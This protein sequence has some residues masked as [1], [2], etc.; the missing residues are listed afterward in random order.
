MSTGANITQLTVTTFANIFSSNTVTANIY[1][2][3][4]GSSNIQN[5][6]VSTGANITQLTVTTLANISNANISTANIYSANVVVANVQYLNISYYANLANLSVSQFANINTAN[7]VTVFHSNLNVSSNANIF[8]MNVFT[9]NVQSTLNAMYATMT[10]NYY[11]NASGVW[12]LNISNVNS[13]T[14]PFS[15]TLGLGA[16]GISINGI[17]GAAGQYITA[18]GTGSGLQWGGPTATIIWAQVPGFVSPPIYYSTANVGMGGPYSTMSWGV[19]SSTVNQYP[20]TPLDVYGGL[21]SFSNLMDATYTGTIRIQNQTPTFG[22]NGGLEFKTG[23]SSSGSGHRILTTTDSTGLSPLIFQFRSSTKTWSNAMAINCDAGN[24]SGYV[25]IGTMNPQYQLHVYQPSVSATLGGILV[26]VSQASQQSTYSLQNSASGTCVFYLNGSSPSDGPANSATLRN[27]AGDLRLAGASTQPYIYLQTATNSVGFG[28]Q[29]MVASSNVSFWCPNVSSSG[30][31]Y[32]VSADSKL[33]VSLYAGD[34]GQ[35]QFVITGVTNT[36]KRLA[37]MYDTSNNISLIQSMT[38][39]TGTNPLILN[40]AGGNVGVGLTNPIRQFSMY[41]EFALVSPYAQSY[42]NVCDANG[43]NGGNYTLYLRGL[44]SSGGAGVNMAGCYIYA[45]NTYLAG[46]VGVGIVNPLYTLQVGTNAGIIGSTTLH[47]ANSYLDSAGQ[48]GARITALDNGV[49]GHNVQIQTR[50]SA[51][52]GFTNSV[53]V[54]SAG[55]VGINNT[56]P[57]APLHVNTTGT[58]GII[59]SGSIWGHRIVYGNYGVS[60]YQDGGSFYYLIT[61]SGDQYG[62]YNSLRPFSF[63]L[64]SGYV[65]MN[66]GVAIYSGLTANGGS[67]LNGSATVN[68]GLTVNG[69]STLNGSATVNSGLTV[70]GGATVNGGYSGYGTQ[71]YFG[72]Y[73]ATGGNGFDFED[74]G[75]FMRMAQRNVRWYDWNGAGDFFYAHNGCVGIRTDQT[76]SVFEVAGRSYIWG[77]SLAGGGQNRFTG[78]EADSSANGRAQLVLNSSYSDMIICS[79]Q[80]N[81]NHGSTISFTTNSTAN[82]DYRKFVINQTNWGTDSTGTGGYGDRLIFDWVDSAQTNPHGVVG[83]AGGTMCIYGRG[84]SIG[85]N[86]VRTPGYNLQVSG[87]DYTSGGRYTS[88]YFRIY[89]GGGIYWQD[90]GGGWYMSDTTY[91]RVYGDKTIYTGGSIYCNS[92]FIMGGTAFL[93]SSRNLINIG[94]I[95]AS[96]SIT[97]GT[98]TVITGNEIA[99]QYYNTVGAVSKYVGVSGY[100]YALGGMEIE[101]TTLGGNW[102][103]KVHFRSHYYGSSNGRRMTIAEG[104]NVG[105]ANEAPAYKFDVSGNI[106]ATAEMLAQEY[107]VNGWFRVNSDGTGLYSQYR[108]HGVT[109]DGATYCNISTFNGGNNG[110]QGYA[111]TTGST[112]NLMFSGNTGGIYMNNQGWVIYNDGA[113]TD[114]RYAGTAKGQAVSYGWATYGLLTCNGDI[115]A[116]YSDERLKEDFQPITNAIDKLKTLDTFTYVS[117]GLARSFDCYKDDTERHVGVSAQQIQ[118]VLPEVV[119]LAPFDIEVK[120]EKITSKSG[121]NYLTVQYDKLV[122]FIMAALKEEI[123]KREALEERLEKLLNKL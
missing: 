121:Q 118:K 117:N 77:N 106:R 96:S 89:G 5:L 38:A 80:T 3:N 110:W 71:N 81:G 32:T 24:L 82:N 15:S 113:N 111:C 6:N 11:G 14:L 86:Y 46:T 39:G 74:Q 12:N 98:G 68:S 63:S 108:N 55:N 90:Y 8:N 95:S 60:S 76:S 48:Y 50:T 70:N 87:N 10:G 26:Q 102:S 43:S 57:S 92:S 122:P 67:T 79:S 53:T 29:T 112:N 41:G 16:A 44:A 52:G 64:S 30:F 2:S 75:S 120:D 19:G 61:N 47:L 78:L 28:T 116:Y 45:N 7:I 20:G 104:G 99:L 109:I 93:D 107:Y 36:N 18:T 1:N 123:Q 22:Y 51:S 85:I 27:N 56:S 33:G 103:Q 54:T 35:G 42:F 9:A 59:S 31:A 115:Q 49:N 101:C 65:N 58:I 69:G 100:G 114:I 66:N 37:F 21:G 13:G 72:G 40:G 62:S 94:S 23:T 4:I 88:D 73:G 34:P 119:K 84:K 105:I 83:T 91:M 17:T 25:G 97:G